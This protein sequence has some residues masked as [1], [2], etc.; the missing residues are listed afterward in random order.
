[1][2]DSAKLYLKSQPTRLGNWL[3]VRGQI[4]AL[5]TLLSY[6]PLNSVLE[7]GVGKGIIATACKKQG[8]SYYGVDASADI[9]R[10][11]A[12]HYVVYCAKVPPLP[13][14]APVVDAII[15]IAVCEHFNGDT[16]M[17]EF[18]SSAKQ[19]LPV[20]GIILIIS[21]D[22]RYWRWYFWDIHHEHNYPTSLRRLKGL[23]YESGFEILKAN[24]WLEGFTWPLS[25][26]IYW[27]T[28]LIPVALL[29]TVCYRS[30]RFGRKAPYSSMWNTIKQKALCAFLVARKVE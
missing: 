14:E 1:M 30:Q 22:I 18:L 27:L 16:E 15:A 8:I 10:T 25:H 17:I 3:K 13:S 6:G 20:G 4:K 11:M 2:I 7:I 29:E 26:I 5:N 21:P 12:E 24:L 28:K 9:C 19:H 23:L